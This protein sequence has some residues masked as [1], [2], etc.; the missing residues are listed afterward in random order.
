MC[1]YKVK[2]KGTPIHDRDAKVGTHS[3]GNGKF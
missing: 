2:G 3:V 1:V